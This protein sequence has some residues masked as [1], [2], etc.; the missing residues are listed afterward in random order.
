MF[1]QVG[2]ADKGAQRAPATLAAAN[3]CRWLCRRDLAECATRRGSARARIQRTRA[4]RVR[5]AAGAAT[6]ITA[7]GN[8]DVVTE[9]P[10]GAPKV[11]LAGEALMDVFLDEQSGARTAKPGG[12]V[13]NCSTALT[14]LET[15]AAFVGCLGQDA[16]GDELMDVL[17]HAAVN[18]AS[19]RR[20]DKYPT[21]R[22]LVSTQPDGNRQFVGFASSDSTEDVL[23]DTALFADS[24]CMDP[25]YV[26]GVLFY[27]AQALVTGTLLLPTPSG[28]AIREMAKIADM[29][30]LKVFVDVNWRPV[31]WKMRTNQQAR[32][33]ILAYLRDCANYIKLSDEDLAFLNLGIDPAEA[34]RNPDRV[35]QEFR[36]AEGV[37]VTFGAKGTSFSIHSN[38][39]FVPSFDN[40]DQVDSTGAGDAFFAGFLSETI[41]RGGTGALID[42]TTCHEVVRFASACGALTVTR[43]GAME[44]QPSRAQVEAFLSDQTV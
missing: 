12:A 9:N 15:A 30:K 26:D 8:R 22:V 17:E 37:L 41:R 31:F 5:L 2:T 23:S 38:Q 21:R 36:R 1:I 13:A 3:G 7:Q 34:L 29:C 27:A 39:G 14:K 44:A 43:Q 32:D 6:S 33:E 20:I 4:K 18:T 25:E 11:I 28:V 16:A 35:R 19:V 24:C 10:L 42:S 40:I